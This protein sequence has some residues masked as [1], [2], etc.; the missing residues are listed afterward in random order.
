MTLL[1]W[2]RTDTRVTQTT[3]ARSEKVEPCNLSGHPYDQKDKSY[4]SLWSATTQID[5]S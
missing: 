1:P 3:Q 4:D 2:G 5:N